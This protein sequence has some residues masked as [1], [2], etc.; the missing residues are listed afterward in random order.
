MHV[1]DDIE[2]GAAANE[3]KWMDSGTNAWDMASRRLSEGLTVE[4][5][6][7]LLSNNS[8]LEQSEC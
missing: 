4:Q 6:H 2:R 5:V 1:K 8:F 3:R 7:L